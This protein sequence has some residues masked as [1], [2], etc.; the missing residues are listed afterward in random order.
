MCIYINSLWA[1]AC[2]VLIHIL[3][4]KSEVEMA[5]YWPSSPRSIKN[6]KRTRGRYPAILTSLDLKDFLYDIPRLHVA[7]CFYYCCKVYSETLSTFVCFYSRWRF[8]FS[9]FLVPSRQRNRRKFFYCHENN[10][11]KK[12]F[13]HPLGLRRKVFAGTKLAISS[14]QYRLILPAR[15]ANQNTEFVL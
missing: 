4:T 15:V 7:L 10:S 8:Q 6:A 2:P 3:L 5:G 13:V 14:G 12:T 11:R 1:C 9:R